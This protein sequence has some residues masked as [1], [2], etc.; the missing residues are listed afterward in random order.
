MARLL[1]HL[2]RQEPTPEQT[3]AAAIQVLSTQA[4]N[5]VRSTRGA[6]FSELAGRMAFNLVASR[7]GDQFSAS[8]KLKPG[9][10]WWPNG[11][12]YLEHA[13]DW[14]CLLSANDKSF[15]P[16]SDLYFAAALLSAELPADVV[17]PLYVRFFQDSQLPANSEQRGDHALNALG[18]MWPNRLPSV[19]GLWLDNFRPTTLAAI[20]N[21]TTLKALSLAGCQ[22]IRDFSQL[23]KLHQ[24]ESLRLDH[25]LVDNI[26]WISA[27]RG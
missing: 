19:E 3:K 4:T 2:E 10:A 18:L 14:V 11:V 22:T 15:E 1:K 21:F 16:N 26:S 27:L 20:S 5:V 24:L 9:E 25:T 12:S 23:G 17:R 6:D 13:G 8:R 7:I